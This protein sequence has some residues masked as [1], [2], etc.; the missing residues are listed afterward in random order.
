M[1]TLLYWEIVAA[2]KMGYAERHNIHSI[3]KITVILEPCA[4]NCHFKRYRLSFAFKFT[5][6]HT[7]ECT[8]VWN[9]QIKKHT[10]TLFSMTLANLLFNQNKL[11]IR[12]C[13]NG[14]K[15]NT[16]QRMPEKLQ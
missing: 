3:Q 5:S 8:I 1:V 15:K 2:G 13:V 14:K 16:F 6:S 4:A 7:S 10:R 9:N 11:S 12:F